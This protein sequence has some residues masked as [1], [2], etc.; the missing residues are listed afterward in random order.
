MGIVRRQLPDDIVIVVGPDGKPVR[1][2]DPYTRLA[3][4]DAQQFLLADDGKLAILPRSRWVDNPRVVDV[5][6]MRFC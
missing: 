4:E 6:F 3:T 5:A 1:R 2:V